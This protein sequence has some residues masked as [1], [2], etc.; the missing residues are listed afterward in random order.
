MTPADDMRGS[1]TDD[2]RPTP[3]TERG[4]AR[5]ARIINTAIRLMWRD[6]FSAVGIDTILKQAGAQKGSFYHFFSSK[7]DLLLACLDHLWGV[8]RQ[9]LE[10]IR[11]AA[12]TGRA[13]LAAHLEWFCEAQRTAHRRYGY[14]PGL[15][16]MSVGVAAVHQ[17]DR[18]AQ[19]FKAFSDEHER[20]LRATLQQI[21]DEDGLA[22]PAG[23]LS[24]LIGHYINGA[25]LK[26][27]VN[28]DIAPVLAIP[29]AVDDLLN[30]FSPQAARG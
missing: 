20:I 18:L 28:N 19:K 14:I 4:Q 24:D 7:T 15:F 27:R 11:A 26:A 8:Q 9:Q 30:H 3:P 1:Q 23:R 25:I 6:G 29:G 22:A 5:R 13:A 21:A 16:H 17:D 10:A 2:G 12:P